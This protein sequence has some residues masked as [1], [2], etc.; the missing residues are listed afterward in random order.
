MLSRTPRSVS[1]R[2]FKLWRY[3]SY[4]SLIELMTSPTLERGEYAA[5]EDENQERRKAEPGENLSVFA[6]TLTLTVK[7]FKTCNKLL[8]PPN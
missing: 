6:L 8:E 5:R 2:G 7:V 3:P 1:Q 4:S